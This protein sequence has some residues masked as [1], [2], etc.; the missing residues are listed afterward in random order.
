MTTY[1]G[2]IVY[3]RLLEPKNLPLKKN[4]TVALGDLLTIDAG[5]FLIQPTLVGTGPTVF[6]GGVFQALQK[7][8][9]GN[10]ADD[11][12]GDIEIQV[13]CVRSRISL[14][15]EAGVAIGNQVVT[16][17]NSNK[18]GKKAGGTSGKY[19]II[20]TV[21]E[22]DENERTVSQDGDIAVIELGQGVI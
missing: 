2:K 14:P 21:Y 7:G 5:G 15:V 11:A 20:G 19:T 18:K 3:Q 4:T 1:S 6:G 22:F 8:S 9:I 12:D 13:A 16:S 10:G 17:N